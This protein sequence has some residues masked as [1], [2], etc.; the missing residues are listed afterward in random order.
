M[1]KS[2]VP[3]RTE[4]NAKVGHYKAYGPDGTVLWQKVDFTVGVDTIP[5]GLSEAMRA[6]VIEDDKGELMHRWDPSHL[7]H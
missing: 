4:S 7:L 3:Q 1:S 6:C 5:G 2:L